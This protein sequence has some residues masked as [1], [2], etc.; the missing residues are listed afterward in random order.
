METTI[1]GYVC[2]G[3]SKGLGSFGSLGS[4]GLR[5]FRVQGV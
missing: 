4:S 1:M 2:R 3:G 5:E